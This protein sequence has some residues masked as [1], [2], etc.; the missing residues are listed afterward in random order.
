MQGS[1]RRPFPISRPVC[2]KDP[3][4]FFVVGCG[5]SGSTLLRLI[6][7]RHSRLAIP[8]ETKFYLDLVK[9]LPLNQPLS[10][11]QV[12][13]ACDLITAREQWS[14]FKLS[15]AEFRSEATALKSPRLRDVMDLIYRDYRRSKGKARWGDKTPGYIRIA[16]ELAEVYPDAKFIYLVRDGRDVAKSFN[17]LRWGGSWWHQRIAPWVDIAEIFARHTKGPL[18]DRFL[19]VRYEDLVTR[20][21]LCVRDICRFL[22]EDFEPRML[23][24]AAD[25]AD[26]LEI[27][28]PEI[29][30]KIFREPRPADVNRW[31][32]ELSRRQLWIVESIA[33]RQLQ[34]GGYPLFYGGRLWAPLMALTRAALPAL[35]APSQIRG[36]FR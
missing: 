30:K 26:P 1:I 20:S 9:E 15:A 2:K 7:S 29:H 34:A 14:D 35:R 36:G 11:D 28:V 6:L 5:R 19:R 13:R 17:D 32:R 24:W 3:S 27:R 18:G 12:L 4:P 10:E 22:G 21:E 25:E 8:P 23:D 31:R 33:K 16:S